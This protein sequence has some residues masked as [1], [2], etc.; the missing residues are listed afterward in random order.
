[1]LAVQKLHGWKISTHQKPTLSE[2]RSKKTMKWYCALLS[3]WLACVLSNGRALVKGLKAH[4][5]AWK[6]FQ[7][8]IA[9]THLNTIKAHKVQQKSHCFFLFYFF[10]FHS[11]FGSHKN[12]WNMFY[13]CAFLLFYDRFFQCAVCDLHAYS[14][15]GVD[16]HRELCAVKIVV[17]LHFHFIFILFFCCCF[18]LDFFFMLEET[19]YPSTAANKRYTFSWARYSYWEAK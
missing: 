1:M 15:F 16:S 8:P 6:S 3:P 12:S 2:A 18:K 11:I 5:Y 17:A 10:I 14:F 7:L 19:K 13:V 9:H 4:R